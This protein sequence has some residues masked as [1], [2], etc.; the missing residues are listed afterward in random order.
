MSVSKSD[1]SPPNA[2]SSVQMNPVGIGWFV[3]LVISAIPIYWIG[4]VFLGQTWMTPEYSH[5]PLIPA[6]SLYLFLRE[7]RDKPFVAEHTRPVRWPGVVVIALGLL[8]GVLGNFTQI[9]DIATYG[10]II[11][12]AGVVL[13]VFGWAQ[14]RMHQLPVLHLVFMLALP[15]IIYWK[16]STFLQMVSSKVGVWFV[17]LAGVPVFLNGNIIDLGVYQLHVAEACSGLRY[18]F[19]ILSFS[20]LTAILYRGPMWH[21]VLLFVAAAPISVL[22]NAFRIG[23]IGVIVNSYGIEHAD[24]FLHYFE[25]WVIFLLCIALL[26]LMAIGLQRLT[27]NPRPLSEAIDLDFEGLPAQ[28]RRIF[29]IQATGGLITATVVTLILSVAFLLVPLPERPLPD[30]DN[31]ALFPRQAGEWRGTHTPLSTNISEALGADDYINVGYRNTETGAAINFFSAYYNEQISG[32]GI[33]S[34]EVC[35][36]GSGWEMFL[37][38]QQDISMPDTVYGDFVVNRAIIQKGTSK[39]LVYYWFEQRGTRMTNDYLAKLAVLYDS[40]VKGR[41][42]GA[43]VRYVTPIGRNESVED[44]DARILELMAETLPRLPRFVPE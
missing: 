40:I 13:T 37:I 10:M 6:I 42:D 21:K 35:L 26:F 14:G 7:L 36:P 31:F 4:M 15:G 43:L 44:A 38:E 29:G 28:A 27:R 16:M 8:V 23:M 20:Y 24:G 3:L 5:G 12:T 41:S 25:G 39:Q 32:S 2:L 19:P 30:R 1:I 18:L 34:P 22:M 17:D 9:P 11:W 33:H